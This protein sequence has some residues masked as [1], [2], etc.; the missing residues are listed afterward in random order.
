MHSVGVLRF[1]GNFVS[2]SIASA[3][4]LLVTDAQASVSLPLAMS[5]N[6]LI[7]LEDNWADKVP[8][9]HQRSGFFSLK[10]NKSHKQ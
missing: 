10:Y 3:M 4:A 6:R 7:I 8:R 9:N 1:S 5:F 2:P